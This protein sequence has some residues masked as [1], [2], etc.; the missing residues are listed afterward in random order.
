[1]RVCRFVVNSSR[2]ET[3]KTEILMSRKAKEE[4]AIKLTKLYS[5]S[6]LV[7]KQSFAAKYKIPMYLL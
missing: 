5:Q 6:H 1:M 2:V 4:S 3:I 7:I